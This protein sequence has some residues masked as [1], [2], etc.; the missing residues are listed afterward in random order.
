MTEKLFYKNSYICEAEC[1]VENIIEKGDSYEVILKST[2]FYPEGGGQTCDLGTIDNIKVEY[3]YE[4]DDIIYHVLKEK[5]EGKF[6]MCKVDYDRRLDHIQQHSGEHLLSA[7]FFKL[8]KI[9]N[10]GFH[11]G[12][13]YV[14][15]DM[16]FK[17]MTEEM[18]REIENEVN[19]YIYRNEPIS[20]YFLT[21][22]EAL[23]LPL[24]KGIK[25]EGKIRIVQ[26]GETT[27]FSACCGTHVVRTG[28]VGIV[29]IIKYENYKGMTRIYFKCGLRALKDY[30]EKQACITNLTRSLSV[31]ASGISNVINNQRNE[32]S[33]LKRKL[34][35][36]YGNLAKREADKLLS[37]SESRFITA[38][39]E[40][41]GFEFLEK[42]YDELKDKGYI[43][44]L[45]SLKDK[46]LILAHNGSFNFKCGNLFKEKLKDFG[47]KGGGNDKRA[48]ASFEVESSIKNFIEYL[49]EVL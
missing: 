47:G 44:I 3:V 8:F 21:K 20:T 34:S 40:E 43:L 19:K 17:D 24:R 31:E 35:D 48:Q 5:P 46:K 45:G 23:K 28:E 30:Q 36:L 2:P 25:A 11:L 1:E 42:L 14:T 26:M 9:V 4:E 6:V 13:D 29:K 18:I 37:N 22:E 16:L 27:D 7:A 32:I 39:Y 10:A 15:I 49:R 12:E 38:T 33:E 41:E